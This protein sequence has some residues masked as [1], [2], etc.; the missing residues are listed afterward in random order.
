M[1]LTLSQTFIINGKPEPYCLQTV[2]DLLV[3]H[4]LDPERPGIAV[5]INNAVVRQV[6][7]NTIQL[8]PGDRVEIIRAVAGG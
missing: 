7:W 8:Q 1:T 2:R 3:A 4:G 5:A 6:E